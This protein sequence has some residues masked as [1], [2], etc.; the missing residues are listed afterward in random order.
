MAFVKIA[1]NTS[2]IELLLFPNTY[3]QTAWLWQ[4]DNIVLVEGTVN[5]KDKDGNIIEEIKI[6][7]SKAR[8]LNIEEVSAYKGTGKAVKPI[9]DK[10]P[11]SKISSKP[12]QKLNRIYLRLE[13]TDNTELLLLLKQHIDKFRGA[14]EVVLVVGSSDNKQIIRVPEK[15]SSDNDSIDELVKLFGS[16]NVK[17]G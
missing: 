12:K 17:L 3:E 5:S 1:D 11:S 7:V 2:E 13:S 8:E 4:I 10:K 6:N 14:S 15:T 9:K 16:E